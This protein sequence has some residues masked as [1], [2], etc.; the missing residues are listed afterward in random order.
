[1]QHASRFTQLT[2][3]AFGIAGA[4]AVGQVHASGF[5]IKE[6]SVKALG[7]AFAGSAVVGG[8]ASVVSTNPAAMT[9]FEGTA[10]QADVTVIDL[11]FEFEGSGTDALGRPM[12]GGDGG[13]AGDVIP[14]PAMSFVHKLD[15]GVALGA[16][17]SAPFGLVTDY[18]NDWV[19]RY[20]ADK[21]DLQ[22][23]DL[24][25]SGAYD[26]IP[27]RFS[28]GLGVIYERADVTLSRA[29][30]FGT[31]L[32]A[33]S[34]NPLNCANPAF[35]YHPQANDGH[36]EV[37]GDSTG[38][39]WLIG[40]TLRPTD[41]LSIGLSYRSEIDHEIEGS[42][43]WTVPGAVRAGLNANPRTAPLFVNGP[44]RADLTTPSV[45]TLSVAYQFTDRFAMMADWSQTGWESLRE[46]NID[47]ANPDPNSIEEF[48]WD[49][50]QFWSLGAEY[51][52]N[53]AWTLRGGYAY[54]ETPTHIET[55]TPRLPDEDRQWLSLG[56]SWQ[57]TPNLEVNFAY[58]YL[59]AD[60]PEIDLIDAQGH[61]LVGTYDASI[62]LYGISAQYKF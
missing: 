56:A 21:S 16:M 19:G 22:T 30:D 40:T 48:D 32:C 60:D 14:V 1:M 44:A 34:G 61:T 58:T 11:G 37:E 49:D 45:T 43:D 35:P 10:F 26:I 51:K 6:N 2:A 3:L 29:V 59:K 52:L 33:G 46:V 28:V 24:T 4:L 50:T 39:G 7:R 62:N 36:A 42:V 17:V 15:N 31:I 38:W 41:K 8:D 20:W 57:A 54:D 55:R 23:V 9:Q 13:N 12:T 53:E 5:Q 25:L 47:F 27:E 18:D